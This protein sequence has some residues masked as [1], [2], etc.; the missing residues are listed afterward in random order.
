[1]HGL[2]TAH[3][4]QILEK[5][6]IFFDET[7]F[8]RKV[9]HRLFQ[10]GVSQRVTQVMDKNK[11]MFIVERV[12]RFQDYVLEALDET[13]KG[14][15]HY[16]VLSFIL[17]YY[18][19]A[20]A[21]EIPVWRESDKKVGHIDLMCYE[22]PFLYLWDYKP[23]ASKVNACGQLVWYRELWCEMLKIN[24]RRIKIGWFDEQKEYIVEEPIIELELA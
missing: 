4:N 2:L 22:H 13:K 24:F 6:R 16:K 15:R 7:V 1:M 14:S 3:N 20:I 12:S 18:D 21:I 10:D 11:E 9:P 19:Y 5:T 17:E 23:N 8:G